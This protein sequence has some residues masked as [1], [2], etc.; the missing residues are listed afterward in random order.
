MRRTLIGIALLFVT[1]CGAP[2]ADEEVPA[3]WSSGDDAPLE[4]GDARDEA[5]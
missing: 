2:P 1:A 4:D 3:V 5:E